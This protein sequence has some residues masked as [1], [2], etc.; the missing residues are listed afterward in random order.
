ML[1]GFTIMHAFSDKLGAVN[2][3]LSAPTIR[4]CIITENL[5]SGIYLYNGFGMVLQNCIISKNAIDGVEF[6]YCRVWVT[7]CTVDSNQMG[8]IIA[9]N[10]TA[11][12][13]TNSQMIGNGSIGLVHV[14]FTTKAY[15]AN[16][17]FVRNRVGFFLDGDFPKNQTSDL[18]QPRKNDRNEFD[19]RF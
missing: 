13:L 7:E 15:I 17:T 16:C 14:A 1:D 11:L 2:C 6:S 12:N 19:F 18:A 9:Y 5:R 4:N 8:G 10:N 3:E